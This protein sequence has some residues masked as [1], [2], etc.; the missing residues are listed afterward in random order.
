MSGLKRFFRI[1]PL[2][3]STSAPIE[4]AVQTKLRILFA[5]AEIRDGESDHR[6]SVELSY[7]GVSTIICTLVPPEV[8]N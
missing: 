2:H 8:R 6:T 1:L 3:S 4:V 5:S 7:D